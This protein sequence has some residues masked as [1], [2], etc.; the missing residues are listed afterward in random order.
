M[1]KIW[2]DILTKPLSRTIFDRLAT[3]YL[4]RKSKAAS[5]EEIDKEKSELDKEQK[6]RE[7]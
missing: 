3:K 4:F 2:P 5:G 7:G 1:K 6:D